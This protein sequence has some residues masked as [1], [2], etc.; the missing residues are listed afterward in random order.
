VPAEQVEGFRALLPVG[1]E[2]GIEAYRAAVNA[3]VVRDLTEHYTRGLGWFRGEFVP[4]LKAVLHHLSGGAWD[5]ADFDAFA[6]GSDVDFMTHLVE[7]VSAREGVCL[8]PGDWHGFRVGCTHPEKI[9]WEAD[10][11]SRL[12]CLCVPSVRNGH[13][14]EEMLAFLERADACLLNLNL[15]PTLEPEERESVARGLAGVLGKAVLSISFSRGFG[16]TASQLGVALVRRDH[17]YRRQ[18]ETAWEWLT[19][20]HNALAARAFLE[21]D[22]PRLGE[23]DRQRQTWVASWLRERGLPVV[24]TGRVQGAITSDRSARSRESPGV[25]RR[26]PGTVWCGYASSRRRLPE[27]DRRFTMN[28]HVAFLH[29]ILEHP[30]EDVPRLIYADWLD[31][32]DEADRAEFIRLQVEL[33]QLTMNDARRD[34]LQRRER[35]LIRRHKRA[36]LGALPT[37]VRFLRFRRGFVEVKVFA[38]AVNYLKKA[39]RWHEH[40]PLPHLFHVQLADAQGHLP[41]VL[42]TPLMSRFVE[43]SLYGSNV[44]DEGASLLASAPSLSRLPCLCL[45]SNRVGPEGAQVL[46]DSHSLARLTSLDLG[47]NPVG[48]AGAL[49]LAESVSLSRL[50]DLNLFGAG[51]GDAGALALAGSPH[52]TALACLDLTLNLIGEAGR[53]ALLRRFGDRVLVGVERQYGMS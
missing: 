14:T 40:T 46:A 17:P 21:L 38:R 4:R 52:L 9:L 31:E 10:S 6:A 53:S 16:L 50:V 35:S 1:Y 5:L 29:D 3:L 28:R 51:I 42:A 25:W 43:L 19:Y 12:A 39:S 30:D 45:H 32:H 26:W 2:A 7:A 36:W 24:G 11:A 47:H 48:N 20:F 37:G 23:V 22:L 15:F 44:G 8:Y 27:P 41:A 49:A 34:A 18:Y 13:L 33:A